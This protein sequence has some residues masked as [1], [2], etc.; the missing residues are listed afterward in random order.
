MRHRDA[1]RTRAGTQDGAERRGHRHRRLAGAAS[2]LSWSDVA[3]RTL[4]SHC[5][6]G[7]TRACRAPR[8]TAGDGALKS[9]KVLVADDDADLRALVSFTLTRAGFDVA[10]AQ[11]G[12]AALQ[13]F[14]REAP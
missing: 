1:G 7:A 9:M 10:T 6:G 3:S 13:A 8:R 14:R 5:R 11:T 2:V 4:G 12:E